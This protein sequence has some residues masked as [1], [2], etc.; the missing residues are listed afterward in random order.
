M[1]VW[2][3]F[4]A[5]Q[6]SSAITTLDNGPWVWVLALKI[7]LLKAMWLE[8]FE[9]GR[10][11][12]Y[13]TE[14]GKESGTAR[15]P[16][17]WNKPQLLGKIYGPCFSSNTFYWLSIQLSGKL[18]HEC[19]ALVLG[20]VVTWE[21]LGGSGVIS[22]ISSAD[23]E[24]NSFRDGSTQSFSKHSKV[25]LAVSKIHQGELVVTQNQND[26]ALQGFG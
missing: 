23:W 2:R 3:T 9:P 16:N 26:N 10:L 7:C 25:S 6:E 11:N 20:D 22:S 15:S 14:S 17:I 24:G 4:T 13:E 19:Q 8:L 1:R 5:G 21:K 12:I 18:E